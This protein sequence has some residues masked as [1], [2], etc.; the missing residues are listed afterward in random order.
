MG[1]N[2]EPRTRA[3]G[4]A[5]DWTS[6]KRDAGQAVRPDGWTSYKLWLGRGSLSRL[7][8]SL[9]MRVKGGLVPRLVLLDYSR[10]GNALTHVLTLTHIYKRLLDLIRDT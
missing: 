3:L 2:R 1:E 8:L 5:V 6:Y 10:V 7:P 9:Y 4:Q